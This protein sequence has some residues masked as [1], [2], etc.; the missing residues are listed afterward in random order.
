M[1][2]QEQYQKML[3]LAHSELLKSTVAKKDIEA[4]TRMTSVVRGKPFEYDCAEI[5]EDYL[6][7]IANGTIYRITVKNARPF[8]YFK[9]IEY[10]VVKDFEYHDVFI[11]SGFVFDPRFSEIPIKRELYMRFVGLLNPNLN[12]QILKL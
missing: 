4:H 1:S 2:V 11:K 9:V 5:A 12:L 10:L 6:D 8:E 3:S 7:E